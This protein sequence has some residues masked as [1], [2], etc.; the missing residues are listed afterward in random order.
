M[1]ETKIFGKKAILEASNNNIEFIQIIMDKPYKEIIEMINLKKIKFKIENKNY[2]KNYDDIN[3]QGCIGIIK[4]KNH[5]YDINELIK[6][7]SCKEKQTLVILDEIEDPRNFGAILRTCVAFGVDGVIFKKDNQS[8]INDLVIKTSMGAVYMLNLCI[9]P[10]I[11]NVIEKLKEN[12]YWI[13]STALNENAININDINF[14][15]KSVIILGNEKKGVSQLTLKKTDFIVKIDMNKN[16]QS[17]NVSVAAGII[18][19]KTFNK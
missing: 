16:I 2:F 5:Q 8:Q 17:L 11:N 15:N 7:L 3:H 6:K 4:I 9:V 19:N 10:N 18:L 1:E 14:D 12:N 13:Y